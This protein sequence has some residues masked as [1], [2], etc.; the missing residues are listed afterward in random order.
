MDNNA[1]EHILHY[2][3]LLV[4]IEV[5]LRIWI[6]VSAMSESISAKDTVATL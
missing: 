2:I 4:I 1:I 3:T 6:P 5:F